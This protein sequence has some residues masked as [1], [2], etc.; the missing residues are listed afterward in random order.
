MESKLK[1]GFE[2]LLEQFA[3]LGGPEEL[4]VVHI[5][6]RNACGKRFWFF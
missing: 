2:P 3:K 6:R 5:R 1:S 4:E